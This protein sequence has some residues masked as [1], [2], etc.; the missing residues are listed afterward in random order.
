LRLASEL[1][2][3]VESGFRALAIPP[4]RSDADEATGVPTTARPF[5]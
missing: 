3:K 5:A 1:V 2:V 4:R